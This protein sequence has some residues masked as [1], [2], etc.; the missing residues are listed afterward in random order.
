M[1]A[2]TPT[3]AESYAI[4]LDGI[5]LCYRLAKHRIPSLKEYAI[6]LVKGALRYEKLW[7]LQ[8]VSLTIHRGETV[9]IVGRNGAG[10][11]TLLKVIS[12]VLKPTA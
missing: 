9:G 3:E 11:S 10:K 2:A 7:A 5:S 1:I 6:H 8:D 4:S 12:K